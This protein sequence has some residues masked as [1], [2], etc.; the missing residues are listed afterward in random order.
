MEIEV[1]T[2][3]KVVV[4][5][6]PDLDPIAIYLEDYGEGR[7]KV[8]ITCFSE[9]WTYYWGSMGGALLDFLGR[10]SND[11]LVRKFL[12]G[13]KDTEVDVD[14]TVKAAK[15][16]LIRM[17]REEGVHKD[18]VRDLWDGLSYVGDIPEQMPSDENELWSDIFGDCFWES[19]RFKASNEYLYLDRIVT[20]VKLGLKMYSES[21]SIR[22]DK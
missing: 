11:Y 1:S 15:V 4:S 3:T 21:L 14:A 19:F 16:E 2:A 13:R 18:R 9:S 12:G 10:C 17:R 20:Q 7:G 6:V 8:V 22:G 5:K